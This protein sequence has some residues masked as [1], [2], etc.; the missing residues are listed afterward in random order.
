[1]L[2]YVFLTCKQIHPKLS[3]QFIRGAVDQQPDIYLDELRTL[4]FEHGGVDASETT[5]WCTL[6][7]MGYT[8]K[9]VGFLVDTVQ[10]TALTPSQMI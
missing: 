5:I 1:M 4:L 10:Y 7:C 3:F 8:M 9:K 2:G 6:A